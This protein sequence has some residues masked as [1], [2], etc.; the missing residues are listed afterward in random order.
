MLWDADCAFCSRAAA[1]A[2]AHFPIEATPYQ[3]VDVNAYGLTAQQCGQA[4]QVV[5][6]AT[7]DVFAGSDAVS[8]VLRTRAGLWLAAGRFG[9]WGPVR[10]VAKAIYRLAAANR[11]RLPGG[12]TACALPP[13]AAR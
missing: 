9:A 13:R 3:W 7:G 4:L 11:H 2:S 10:P 5:D 8:R 1:Y 6:R 12:T